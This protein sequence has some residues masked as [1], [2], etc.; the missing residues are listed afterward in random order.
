MLAP[1]RDTETREST[2]AII[3]QILV[4]PPTCYFFS[5]IPASPD[6]AAP[7]LSIFFPAY[8]DGGT[9]ASL[10][11]TARQAAMQMTA[12]FEVL[13]INDGS[14]DHTPE[15]ADELAYSERTIKNVIQDITRR[16]GVRNRSHAV[17]YA[18]RQGLI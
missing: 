2:G 8:N 9:I 3:V 14:S 7:G 10:V 16:L 11:L 5:G 15:I 1:P 13:I 4:G 12:D 18:L 17:A 6:P